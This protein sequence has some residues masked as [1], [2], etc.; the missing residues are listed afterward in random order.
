MADD[1]Q[2]YSATMLKHHGD[3][4][5][6]YHAAHFLIQQY[7]DRAELHSTE[8]V[9]VMLHAGDLDG[10]EAWQRILKAVRTLQAPRKPEEAVN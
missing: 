6:I 7:G 9:L 5:E 10:A 4:A 3:P 2:M 8:C 1:L